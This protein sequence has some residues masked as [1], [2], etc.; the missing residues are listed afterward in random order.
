MSRIDLFRS[1]LHQDLPE[2]AAPFTRW[3]N[4]RLVAVERGTV[5][6]RWVVREEAINAAGI[7]HGG[8]QAAM[9]DE[10]MGTSVATLDLPSFHISI[11]LNVAFLGRA[12]L[13]DTVTGTGRVVREGR[14]VVYCEGELVDAEGR[15][16]ARASSNLIG[17]PEGKPS[18]A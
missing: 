10:V 17:P 8:I 11:D 14:R 7:L 16:M 1:Y 13:G 3:L 5:T 6:M 2:R 18:P 12:K 4:G 9:L 15:L